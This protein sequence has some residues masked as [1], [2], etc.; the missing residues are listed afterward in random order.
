M[1]RSSEPRTTANILHR[2]SLYAANELGVSHTRTATTWNPGGPTIRLHIGLEDS[3]DLM[4][5]LEQGFRKL[6]V[7]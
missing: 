2:Y 6:G 4:A 3:A 7:A 5:D 1:R